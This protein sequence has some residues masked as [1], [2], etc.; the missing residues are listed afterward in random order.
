M[1]LKENAGQLH[2]YISSVWDSNIKDQVI[3][4]QTDEKMQ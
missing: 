2:V 1:C 3:Q 4:F